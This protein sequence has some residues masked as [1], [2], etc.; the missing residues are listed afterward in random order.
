MVICCVKISS[1]YMT[2]KRTEPT[3]QSADKHR[4]PNSLNNT[5][6]PQWLPRVTCSHCFWQ[7]T[8]SEKHPKT[9]SALKSYKC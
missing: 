4:K 6:Q 1:D 2:H 5:N 3:L 9:L 8:C 7:L